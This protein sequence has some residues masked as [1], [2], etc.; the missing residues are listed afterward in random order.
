MAAQE[1]VTN[2]IA[3]LRQ[4]DDQAA[5]QLF[6]RYIERLKALA[7]QKLAPRFRRASDEEDI[8]M[9]AL[10]TVFRGIQDG[11]FH[12]LNDRD[13]LWRVLVMLVDRRVTDQVRRATAQKR[14]LGQERGESAFEHHNPPSSRQG[15]ITQVAGDEPTPEFAAELIEE[16][17]QRI[18]A[19]D[20]PGLQ[21]IAIQ[22]LEGYSNAEIADQR[23]CT[24]RTIE[25]KLTLIRKIWAGQ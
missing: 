1:T 13:D 16:F 17:N 21:E 10:Q 18:A 22:K 3:S 11:R 5:E 25:R 7:R 19:L 6:G 8:A 15:G 2:W 14:G 24:E 4:R 9:V 20:D 23:G 12:R